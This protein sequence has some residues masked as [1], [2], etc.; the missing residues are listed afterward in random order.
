MQTGDTM[1][2]LADRFLGDSRL[3]F[4]LSRYNGLSAPNALAVGRS[5]KLPLSAK[6][7]PVTTVAN[8]PTATPKA[9]AAKANDMRLQALQLLN[10]GEVDGAIALLKQAVALDAND[11]AIRKDLERAERIQGSLT[12]G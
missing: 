4:A 10:K 2:G 8:A 7:L 12:N 9:A 11:P 5:L 6:R 1:S 3:F